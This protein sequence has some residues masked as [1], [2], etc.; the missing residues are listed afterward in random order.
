MMKEQSSDD[1]WSM[2]ALD[3]TPMLKMSDRVQS[4]DLDDIN[5][6]MN[7]DDSFALP[8]G[9]GRREREVRAFF[10][11]ILNILETVRG[12]AKNDIRRKDN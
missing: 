6:N 4:Y 12:P 5:M 7:S 10:D 2:S 9:K 1:D 8:S 3:S 11:L